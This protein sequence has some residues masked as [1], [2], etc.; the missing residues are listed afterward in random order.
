MSFRPVDFVTIQNENGV[1]FQSLFCSFDIV[2][3][4][5]KEA[6]KGAPKEALDWR[7]S[8][9]IDESECPNGQDFD[10]TIREYIKL[11]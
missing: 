6:L 10:G 9:E 3:M 8:V 5:V 1:V 11:N 7:I 4:M 2:D